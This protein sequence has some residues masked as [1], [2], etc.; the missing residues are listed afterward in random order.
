MLNDIRLHH[1]DNRP[2][3]KYFKLENIV[4]ICVNI[5]IFTFLHVHMSSYSIISITSAII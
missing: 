1:L 3:R 2:K 5:N 4:K